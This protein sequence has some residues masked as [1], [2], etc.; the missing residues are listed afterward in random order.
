[1]GVG[2][3]DNLGFFFY[4]G[5]SL[6]DH[7]ITIICKFKVNHSVVIMYKMPSKMDEKKISYTHD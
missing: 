4:Y 7:S 1:M 5:L 3:D 6:T 2:G